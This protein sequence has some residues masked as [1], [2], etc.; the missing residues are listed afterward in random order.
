[1]IMDSGSYSISIK[2]TV[3]TQKNRED[4]GYTSTLM[5][6]GDLPGVYKY[7]VSNRAMTL[8]VADSFNIQGNLVL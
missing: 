7:A 2:L 1:M 5:V 4:A 8:K 3:V 6:T